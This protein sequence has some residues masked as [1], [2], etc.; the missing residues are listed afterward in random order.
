[1]ITLDFLE[2]VDLFKGMDDNQLERILGCCRVA[3]FKRGDRLFAAGKDAD[4]LWVV[5]NGQVELRGDDS[6]SEAHAS[7]IISTLSESMAFGWSS[8]VSPF[9]YYLSAFCTSRTCNV[10]QVE[11]N[12][13]IQLMEEDTALGYLIMSRLLGLVGQR[14]DQLEEEIIKYLGQNIINQ[15]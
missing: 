11:K 8:L 9:K 1:M 7:S 6:G 12:C 3:D 10:L 5:I 15:W 14:F 13:L 2:S 4:F